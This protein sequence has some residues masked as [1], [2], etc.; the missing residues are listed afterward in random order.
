MQMATISSCPL[1]EGIEPGELDALLNCLGAKRKNIERGEF[2]YRAGDAAHSVGV[3]LSG[4]V[5]VVQEDYW[6]NRSIVAHIEPGGLF[7]EAFASAQVTSLPVSVLAAENCAVLLIGYSRIITSCS[8]ACGFHA[9]LVRNMM[10]ILA[11][12]NVRLT[13]KIEHVTQ[14]STR[15]K[16]LSFLSEQAI[17]AGPEFDI[18][19]NRQELADYLAV[20]RSALSAELSRMS[21]AGLIRFNRNHF[22]LL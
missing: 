14:R 3:L 1:F 16:V 8:N 13:R 15:E 17:A 19:F 6:G 10:G 9:R 4:S 2:V 7:A 21:K 11:R 5:H 12:N 20:E 22:E 18:P